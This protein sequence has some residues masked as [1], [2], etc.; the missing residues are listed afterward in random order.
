[1][2]QELTEAVALLAH[3]GEN[4]FKRWQFERA[5]KALPLA[6]ILNELERLTRLEHKHQEEEPIIRALVFAARAINQDFTDGAGVSGAHSD[7]LGR[8]CKAYEEMAP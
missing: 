2:I 4:D 8:A 6:A 7:A 5:A 3:A 1:M